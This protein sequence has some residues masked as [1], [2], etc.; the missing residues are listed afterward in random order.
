MIRK[1]VL[2]GPVCRDNTSGDEGADDLSSWKPVMQHFMAQ[3]CRSG[4]SSLL[5]QRV[6]DGAYG[7]DQLV[8]GCYA[9]RPAQPADMYVDRSLSDL[10]LG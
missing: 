10:G 2:E 4:M 8:V 7:A 6:A 3:K 1:D 5:A 9:E